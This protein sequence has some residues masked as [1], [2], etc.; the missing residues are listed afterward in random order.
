MLPHPSQLRA[1]SQ[2]SLGT[3]CFREQPLN[4]LE[5]ARVTGGV[6]TSAGAPEI[7]KTDGRFRVPVI[8]ESPCEY[9]RRARLRLP[10][11]PRGPAPAFQMEVLGVFPAGRKTYRVPFLLPGA[12]ACVTSAS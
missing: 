5:L 8:P 11:R 4:K 9:F 7:C 6:I 3:G 10:S 2:V 12:F 1:P